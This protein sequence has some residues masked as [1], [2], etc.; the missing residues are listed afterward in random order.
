MTD[1]F[2]LQATEALANGRRF[3]LFGRRVGRKKGPAN[4]CWQ[5]S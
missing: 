5:D 2:A 4:G 3:E 1:A